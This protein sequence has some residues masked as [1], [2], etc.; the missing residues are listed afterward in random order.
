M[1]LSV[2]IHSKTF[3]KYIWEESS[4][5]PGIKYIKWPVESLHN[6]ANKFEWLC[7][8]LW[9]SRVGLDY[10]LMQKGKI[11]AYASM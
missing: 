9:Y 6:L 4:K 2:T 8:L 7:S 3:P 11:I 5:R 10:I 1:E